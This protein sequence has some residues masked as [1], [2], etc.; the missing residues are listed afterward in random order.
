MKSRHGHIGMWRDRETTIQRS[1]TTQ[2]D[3]ELEW[4][5]Y[6]DVQM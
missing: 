5:K 6:R 2:R 4:Q 1:R 3:R